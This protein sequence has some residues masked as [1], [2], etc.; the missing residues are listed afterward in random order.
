[1][2]HIHI[3]DPQLL[4]LGGHYLNHDGQLI[5]E[6]QRRERAGHPLRPQG[7]RPHLRGP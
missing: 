3:C 7:L 1:M 4:G 6:L 2:R 5:R